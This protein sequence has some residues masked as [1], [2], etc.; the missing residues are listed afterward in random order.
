MI[1]MRVKKEAGSWHKRLVTDVL[2]AIILITFLTITFLYP[3]SVNLFK[4]IV[5]SFIFNAGN[6][7]SNFQCI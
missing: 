3:A 6:D 1:Y 4:F 5:E 7:K 2:P